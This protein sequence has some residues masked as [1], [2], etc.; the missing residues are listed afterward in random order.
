MYD[1][2]RITANAAVAYTCTAQTPNRFEGDLDTLVVCALGM[3][4]NE[5]IIENSAHSEMRC[6][7][8]R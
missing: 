3:I 5:S 2:G 4:R 7:R 1:G 6:T 8:E